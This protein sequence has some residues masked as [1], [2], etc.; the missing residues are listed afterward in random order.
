MWK[1]L[2]LLELLRLKL[3]YEL[4]IVAEVKLTIYFL[5]CGLGCRS[6]AVLCTEAT[7]QEDE[8]NVCT[9]NCVTKDLISGGLK[10]LTI[11]PLKAYLGSHLVPDSHL[12]VITVYVLSRPVQIHHFFGFQ[13]D[14]IHT[15]LLQIQFVLNSFKCYAQVNSIICVKFRQ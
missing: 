7:V 2:L 6:S 11:D 3:L 5:D 13:L 12:S 15:Q 1:L 10:L 4:L 9:I 8:G 14:Q